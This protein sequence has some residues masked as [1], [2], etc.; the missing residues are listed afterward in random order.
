MLEISVGFQLPSY[1][2]TLKWEQDHRKVVE[3]VPT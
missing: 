3:V 1:G 2:L